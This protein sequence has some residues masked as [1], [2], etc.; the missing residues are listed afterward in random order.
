MA[1]Y[2]KKP[3]VIE[4]VKFDGVEWVD[5]APAAMFEGSF[6]PP[7]TWLQKAL[8]L[9]DSELGAVYADGAN[10]TIR[11]LEGAMTTSPGDYII[12]GVIG[13]IYACKPDVFEATHE[14]V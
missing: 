14:P 5:D 11:T 12:F 3:V 4:A 1:K 7:E 8:A 10:L 9:H 13:E 2:R 6:C